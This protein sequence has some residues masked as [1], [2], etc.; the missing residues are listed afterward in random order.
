MPDT[1]ILGDD[2]EFMIFQNPEFYESGN[3]PWKKA[4]QPLHFKSLKLGLF[5]GKGMWAASRSCKGQKN[6]L[7]RFVYYVNNIKLYPLS[8]RECF[9]SSRAVL[10]SEEWSRKG[11]MKGGFG[12]LL[13]EINVKIQRFGSMA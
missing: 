1:E 13:V 2:L 8:V 9:S 4:T 3:R 6:S 11:Q 12:R 10:R 7:S 5:M